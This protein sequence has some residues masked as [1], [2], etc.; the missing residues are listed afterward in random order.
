MMGMPSC[1]EVARAI[2]GDELEDASTRRRLGVRL[3]LLMCSH[4]RRYARQLRAIGRAAREVLGRPAG[5]EASLEKLRPSILARIATLAPADE[6][7][8]EG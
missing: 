5:E 8:D 4:C 6:A 3:H 1:R 7:P 2:G